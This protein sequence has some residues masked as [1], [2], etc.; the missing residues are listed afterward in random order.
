MNKIE[1]LTNLGG[2]PMTQYTLDFMQSSYHDA[3]AGLSKLIG[4]AVI[5]S[6]ME[7]VGTNVADGW[8][9]YNGE[10]LPFV[11]GPKQT[12]WIVE[13]IAESRVFADQVT[14]DVYFTK[15]ARFASGGIAYSSLQRIETLVSMRDTIASLKASVTQQLN[16]IWKKGDVLEVD[17]DAA[18]IQANFN[19]TG[20]G[21]NERVGWAICNGNNGTK[22]RNGRFSI[23]YD[24]ARTEYNTPGKI[25]GAESVT[26]SVNEMPS[27]THLF[28]MANT[29]YSGSGGYATAVTH[30][31]TVDYGDFTGS[32][33]AAGGS[34]AHENRPPYIVTL[35]I[36]KL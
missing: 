13:E 7:E 12:T 8:I 10:L 1:Q 26:L 23:G 22:V 5:V 34:Q 27:H 33:K 17:C 15:R 19:N 35:F 24:P 28:T 30:P 25:G 20:L 36:Q 6:G 31:I 14:R 16:N 32:M 4:S 9:S 18:Y 11:G 3:L 21:I 2:F 29:S